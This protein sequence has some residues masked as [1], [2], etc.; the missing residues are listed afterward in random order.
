MRM[1]PSGAARHTIVIL[2]FFD[3]QRVEREP[4]HQLHMFSRAGPFVVGIE[5]IER[6]ARLHQGNG[7]PL[8]NL[9]GI[10]LQPDRLRL[11]RVAC[12]KVGRCCNRQDHSRDREQRRQHGNATLSL[13]SRGEANVSHMNPVW[14]HK[15]NLVYPLTARDRGHGVC[16]SHR[17][18]ETVIASSRRRSP[19]ARMRLTALLSRSGIGPPL[20]QA[21]SLI[22][23]AALLAGH[24][25][26]TAGRKAPAARTRHGGVALSLS[27]SKT[28]AA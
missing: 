15:S 3:G 25:I 18:E 22:L 11:M 27:T 9:A 4:A 19:A 23:G 28:F 10:E 1:L 14:P 2:D 26:R 12:G 20:R 17:P 13:L 6:A 8:C 5:G 7:R 16:H 24:I 21:P